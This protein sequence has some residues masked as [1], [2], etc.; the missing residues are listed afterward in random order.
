[1]RKVTPVNDLD[2]LCVNTLRFLAVDEVEKAN[3]GHPVLP[4]GAAPMA[5]VLWDRFLRHHP[6]NLAWQKRDRFILSAGHGCAL[7]YALLHLTGYNLPLEELKRF[8][9]WGSKTP[10]H[11]EY[12]QHEFAAQRLRGSRNTALQV[13]RSVLSSQALVFSGCGLR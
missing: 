6:L 11:P 10:G 3:S 12:G 13:P 4:L 1:M 9:Q 2:Q 7:L 5:Y 8:R